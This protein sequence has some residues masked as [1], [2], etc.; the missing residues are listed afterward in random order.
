MARVVLV[1]V[2]LAALT[3]VAVAGAVAVGSTPIAPGDVLA[4]LA[5]RLTR[6]PR[7]GGA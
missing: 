5:H 7:G 1:T 2:G 4:V 6:R 3:V